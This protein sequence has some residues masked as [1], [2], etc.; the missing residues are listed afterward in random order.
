MASPVVVPVSWTVTS[1]PAEA[2]VTVTEPFAAVT[3]ASPFVPVI[4]VTVTFPLSA[5]TLAFRVALT[6]PRL[7]PVVALVSWMMK[8]RPAV[9]PVRAADEKL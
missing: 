7:R 6:V 2:P 9:G 5:V 1:P 3:V 8:S 4:E